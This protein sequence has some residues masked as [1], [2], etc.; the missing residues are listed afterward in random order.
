MLVQYTLATRKLCLNELAVAL[1]A[2]QDECVNLSLR[3]HLDT[4]NSSA[5]LQLLLS[6][7]KLLSGYFLDS[8]KNLTAQQMQ[9]C[10]YSQAQCS[11]TRT[12]LSPSGQAAHS[13]VV[14]LV[15]PNP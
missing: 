3:T 11:Q 9:F 6:K 5:L 2:T 4:T 12:Y 1:S 15:Y 14:Q 7:L 8:G 13:R 10:H